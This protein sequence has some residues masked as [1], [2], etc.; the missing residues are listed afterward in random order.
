MDT[1]Y[2]AKLRRAP[3]KKHGVLITKTIGGKA[4]DGAGCA[5]CLSALLCDFMSKNF[6]L[7]TVYLLW[8]DVDGVSSTRAYADKESA[9]VG[10]QEHYTEYWILGGRAK[11]VEIDCISYF[12][13]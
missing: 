9:E 8:D 3:T 11:I 2:N 1:K 7:T 5:S 10:L 13:T 6:K 12:N 4:K